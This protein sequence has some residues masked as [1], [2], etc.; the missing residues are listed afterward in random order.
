MTHVIRE[1]RKCL[2]LYPPPRLVKSCRP[3]MLSDCYCQTCV[4]IER[5]REEIHSERSRVKSS[6]A[7]PETARSAKKILLTPAKVVADIQSE[8]RIS[9]LPA[10]L[11]LSPETSAALEDVEK[12]IKDAKIQIKEI[13]KSAGSG[14]CKRTSRS[15]Y[16]GEA[17]FEDETDQLLYIRERVTYKFEEANGWIDTICP[18]SK[19]E[20]FHEEEEEEEEEEDDVA[21]KF[22][23]SV[24]LS[25]PK[26]RTSE[27]RYR[28]F[29]RRRNFQIEQLQLLS[30]NKEKPRYNDEACASSLSGR[31]ENEEENRRIN[32]CSVQAGPSVDIK[33]ELI[34]QNLESIHISPNPC[35]VQESQNVGTYVFY[36]DFFAENAS[37]RRKEKFV[38]I[39]EET[40]GNNKNKTRSINGKQKKKRPKESKEMEVNDSSDFSQVSEK[41]EKIPE[42]SGIVTTED[43]EESTVVNVEKTV[44]KKESLTKNSDDK[45]DRSEDRSTEKSLRDVSN[46]KHEDKVIDQ[47]AGDSTIKAASGNEQKQVR[48][49]EQQTSKRE[50]KKTHVDELPSEKED[51]TVLKEDLK[52]SSKSVEPEGQN[53]L[54]DNTEEL[55]RPSSSKTVEI[56]DKYLV[57]LSTKK[58]EDKC[59][60]DKKRHREIWGERRTEKNER[61]SVIDERF[62][63]IL[64]NY[65]DLEKKSRKNGNSND[66]PSSIDSSDNSEES[67]DF[68]NL[69]EPCFDELD[70]V[71]VAYDKT[72]DSVARSA[73]T[74]DKFLSQPELEEYFVEASSQSLDSITQ[75]SERKIKVGLTANDDQSRPLQM[76]E[77]TELRMK[78]SVIEDHA[79]PTKRHVKFTK[80]ERSK[81]PV[82]VKD[83]DNR[84]R[85]CIVRSSNKCPEKTELKTKDRSIASGK[86]DREATVKSCGNSKE[87]R[88]IVKSEIGPFETRFCQVENGGSSLSTVSMC[89]ASF[90]TDNEF[91]ND[92][93]ISEEISKTINQ[94]YLRDEAA[95][96][97]LN[98]IEIEDGNFDYASFHKVLYSNIL[99]D[100][101]AEMKSTVRGES[102]FTEDEIRKIFN[103]NEIAPLIMKSLLESLKSDPSNLENF[104]V[105]VKKLLT[106]NAAS[107]QN[108]KA[109]E[110]GKP[111]G[112][113][114]K[115][116]L[117][118]E[119]PPNEVNVVAMK[120]IERDEEIVERKSITDV[121]ESEQKV[122]VPAECSEDLLQSKEDE[123]FS[124]EKISRVNSDVESLKENSD[125]KS[126]PRSSNKNVVSQ[127]NEVNLQTKESNSENLSSTKSM[128]ND[129]REETENGELNQIVD[130]LRKKSISQN[131][132][133]K[134]G[135]KETEKISLVAKCE[136][137]CESV[138]QKDSR[139][140]ET[141]KENSV[142]SRSTIENT[143]KTAPRENGNNLSQVSLA[144]SLHDC[145]S[146][147]SSPRNLSRTTSNEVKSSQK[148]NEVEHVIS[149]GISGEVPHVD[150]SHFD[151]T[152]DKEK[153]LLDIYNESEMLSNT[154]QSEGELYIPCS[155]SYS[156]G[157]V[158]ILTNNQNQSDGENTN[159]FNDNITDFV[160]NKMPDSCNES[161]KIK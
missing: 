70:I 122:T 103:I 72:I 91:E 47:E 69:Y 51:G 87:S 82:D 139:I 111:N 59:A 81:T 15:I 50:N 39:V 151:N 93:E 83:I 104:E 73:R 48:F 22:K 17:S 94:Q 86:L 128:P 117:Q 123:N 26:F 1:K 107:V 56:N 41:S 147:R 136:E 65:C 71:L 74:I 144:D 24:D 85:K 158:R 95:N 18:T 149:A 109:V 153:I 55:K 34:R 52:V 140:S 80:F 23:R 154:W 116:N 20:Q 45:E 78:D 126:G 92:R 112:E 120:M 132:N 96:L 125:T 11:I 160:T 33:G 12:L 108:I 19:N 131:E 118:V 27:D 142:R 155:G 143:G 84:W 54:K 77:N 141:R 124:V 32:S 37:P 43:K 62:T 135:L 13:S 100:V 97:K 102:P 101:L 42:R 106:S 76:K 138:T 8:N 63:S 31:R 60:V 159:D 35:F 105:F 67:C 114:E 53:V 146:L 161:S 49:G 68:Y 156:L 30:G 110:T 57:P 113:S 64:K 66:T 16:Q 25:A 79:R 129:V 121:S 133:G 21:M 89:P 90:S 36:R 150:T 29:S 6:R 137:K 7:K 75:L 61:Y 98:A 127:A 99:R 40:N 157:E 44:D 3:T 14:G 9:E 119:Y 130:T 5:Q 115:R 145:A 4:P 10:A 46:A 58:I 152:F 2:D 134:D 38:R 148:V 28:E 88:K